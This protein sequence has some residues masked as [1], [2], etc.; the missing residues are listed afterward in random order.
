[1]TDNGRARVTSDKPRPQEPVRCRF[2]LLASL[3]QF[4]AA[5]AQRIRWNRT[6]GEWE[7]YGEEIAVYDVTGW[8]ATVDDPEDETEIVRGKA[9][10]WPDTQHWEIYDLIC[11][12]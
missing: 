9:E 10:Y 11:T 8:E 4:A 12:E 2:R 1:M 3:T 5:Q 7:D 6:T